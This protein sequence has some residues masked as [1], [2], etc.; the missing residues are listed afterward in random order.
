MPMLGL[1]EQCFA[2]FIM[3]S[4]IYYLK[5]IIKKRLDISIGVY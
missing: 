2:F 1:S 3:L 4:N 5:P